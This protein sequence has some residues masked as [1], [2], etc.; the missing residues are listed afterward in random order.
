MLSWDKSTRNNIRS[1]EN[2]ENKFQWAKP[3]TKMYTSIENKK[4]RFQPFIV[5]CLINASKMPES[6]HSM[7]IL[8]VLFS[9]CCDTILWISIMLFF[10]AFLVYF[11]CI[12]LWRFYMQFC[13]GLIG[14]L[15]IWILKKHIFKFN[16]HLHRIATHPMR[17][18]CKSVMVNSCTLCAVDLFTHLSLNGKS[19]HTLTIKIL[20]FE[21]YN[22]YGE[23]VHAITIQTKPHIMCT[24]WPTHCI[25]NV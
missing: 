12:W 5:L 21:H 6:Q 7:W 1:G 24:S 3:T 2:N 10:Y 20:M 23:N 8:I 11:M 16:A 25:A 9:N 22:L 13:D 18:M 4:F 17:K 15:F 14:I 19:M